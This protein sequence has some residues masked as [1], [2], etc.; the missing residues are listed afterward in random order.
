MSFQV[1]KLLKGD[2]VHRTTAFHVVSSKTFNEDATV[3]SYIEEFQESCDDLDAPI[4]AQINRLQRNLKGLPP[5]IEETP[6]PESGS[7]AAEQSEGSKVP[8]EEKS[9]G[10]KIV[11]D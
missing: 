1:R 4:L 5:L 8:L 3:V 10:K 6:A 11:F 2:D 7:A 9:K